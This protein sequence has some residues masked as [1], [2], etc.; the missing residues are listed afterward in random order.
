M[1]E[2]DF[3]VIKKRIEKMFDGQTVSENVVRQILDPC[4]KKREKET[5]VLCLTKISIS[6]STHSFRYLTSRPFKKK[7]QA[8]FV[9]EIIC[10]MGFF[11]FV[12][13][14]SLYL[15]ADYYHSPYGFEKEDPE[16]VFVPDE[17][18][19]YLLFVTKKM[20]LDTVS[21]SPVEIK[22]HF[23]KFPPHVCVYLSENFPFRKELTWK[24]RK[25]G[26][27]VAFAY[28]NGRYFHC[29][30]YLCLFL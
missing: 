26:M 19:N 7:Q 8:E 11:V 10:R 25:N 24:A 17:F 4:R 27:L 23:E 1:N 21:K 3:H 29:L 22:H 9:A 6:S 30:K 18:R 2:Q 20:Y 15:F 14:H 5:E 13:A 16:I 12:S 28:K